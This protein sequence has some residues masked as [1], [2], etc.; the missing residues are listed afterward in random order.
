MAKIF[1]D[2]SILPK[3]FRKLELSLKVSWYYIWTNCD[4]SG[5]YEIDEDLFEFENGFELDLDNFLEKLKGLVEYNNGKILLKDFILINQCEISKLNP[6]YNPHK[7]V[8]RAI[9]K[10]KLKLNPSLNQASF[11]L[12][13]EVEEEVIVEVEEEVGVKIKK[14]EKFKKFT[15]SD[16]K[17]TFLELGVDEIYLDD[18]LAVRKRKKSVNSQSA[19][20]KIVS[21]CN[22]HNYPI[23]E[24]IKNCAE[25]SWS[26]FKF[27][28]LD[29]IYSKKSNEKPK[30]INRQTEEVIR[31]NAIV[32]QSFVESLMN[33]NNQK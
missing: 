3:S 30:T 2:N 24:A 8:F 9:N 20:K 13:V 26:G 5:V 6:E 29:N 21:E 27:E 22:K 31:Q 7:P 32:D 14:E 1:I 19:L 15:S 28:W 33:Q 10:N 23:S 17:K 25:N 18:W 12:V 16:F 11:K 4:S